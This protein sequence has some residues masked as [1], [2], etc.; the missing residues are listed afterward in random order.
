ME[1]EQQLDHISVTVWQMA[2]AW[3]Y[4]ISAR[5][6]RGEQMSLESGEVRGTPRPLD[7]LKGGDQARVVLYAC[8]TDQTA[9]HPSR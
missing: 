4:T 5:D 7:G 2:G 3:W 6:E 9:E 1:L 8:V